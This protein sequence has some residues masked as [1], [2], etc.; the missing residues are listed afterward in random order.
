MW[1]LDIVPTSESTCRMTLGPCFP[2]STVARPDFEEKVQPY[3]ERWDIA[4]PEDNRI[5][6]LQQIG[7]RSTSRGAG[8]VRRQRVRGAQP[9]QLG[10]GRVLD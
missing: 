3:Y 6:E 10:A 1:W 7:Q 9:C 2:E 4:T 8:A 5:A